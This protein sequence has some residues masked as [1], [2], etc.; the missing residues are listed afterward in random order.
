MGIQVFASRFQ[1]LA[2]PCRVHVALQVG[3][4]RHRLN[5]RGYALMAAAVMPA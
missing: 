5:G 1:A 2:G 3:D 4:Q